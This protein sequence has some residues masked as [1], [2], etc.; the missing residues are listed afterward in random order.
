MV[1]LLKQKSKITVQHK[2]R[3]VYEQADVFKKR[4][5]NYVDLNQSQN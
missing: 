2:E 4:K 5:V 3:K 1:A